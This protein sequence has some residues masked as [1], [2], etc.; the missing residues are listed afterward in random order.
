MQLSWPAVPPVTNYVVERAAGGCGGSFAG[1]ASTATA[2]YTD[3]AV[4]G[5]AT[6]GYRIRTCPFQ[7]SNCAEVTAQGAPTPTATAIASAPNP[8]S[9]GQSVTF[10]ATVTSGNGVPAGTVTFTEGPTVLASAVPVDGAGHAAFATSA[11]AAG[12]HVVT[13]AFTGAAGWANSSGD[14]SAAPQVV[15]PAQTTVTLTSV[16]AQDGW[17][18]ESN[19]TSNAGG[20]LDAAAT[21]TSALRV[22]DDNKNRQYKAV[23]SFD[24]SAI[25]DG[26]TILSATLRLR[27]GTVSGTN[28]FTTHGTCWVDVQTGGLSG[29]TTLQTGDFQAAA[30]AV[31]AASLS[32]AANNGDWSTGSLNA[33][34]L[35]AINKTG[36]T[37]L[38]VYFA[39]D[40]NNDRSADYVG[41]YSGDNATA[42]NWPQLVVIYQ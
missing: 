29:S 20:S 34:G 1:L 28:P 21:T 38:R 8:S 22:G 19:E 26:A 10:T 15:N 2:G 42:A 23:V 39:L 27:R 41:Y 17:V 35:A 4:S 40:D 37:Q 33:A 24:T 6:Y 3:S 13:A 25:P 31:Q 16:A 18:L 5:G 30:T 14:D 12:S 11:L 9:F 36:T 7:V 32:N